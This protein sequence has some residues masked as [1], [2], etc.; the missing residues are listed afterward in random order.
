M[1]SKVTS[2]TLENNSTKTADF[3]LKQNPLK[4]PLYQKEFQIPTPSRA[5]GM[6]AFRYCISPSNNYNDMKFFN[7]T[8]PGRT[9]NNHFDY[10]GS[11]SS[12]INP[13][14]N[15]DRIFKTDDQMQGAKA[16][17]NE[18]AKSDSDGSK[19]NNEGG[20]ENNN[21]PK[22]RPKQL[23]L[24]MEIIESKNLDCPGFFQ[25]SPINFPAS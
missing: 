7:I 11:T 16:D 6:N 4:S 21:P 14:R 24:D 12:Q 25:P 5:G 15:F 22:F 9:P 2:K 23:E 13:M 1:K 17:G 3:C 10:F 20:N 8:T 18:Q 19:N